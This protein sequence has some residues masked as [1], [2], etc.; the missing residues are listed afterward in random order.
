MQLS[1]APRARR[2]R[3]HI[4]FFPRMLVKFPLTNCFPRRPSRPGS[5][6]PV[7]QKYTGAVDKMVRPKAL[8]TK[9]KLPK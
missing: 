3:N 1:C 9:E 7:R 4:A 6:A 5:S 8:V 2:Q